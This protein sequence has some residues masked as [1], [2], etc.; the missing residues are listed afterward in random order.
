MDLLLIA[1][2]LILCGGVFSLLLSRSPM[3]A[4]RIGV[5]AVVAG[6]LLGLWPA[7]AGLLGGVPEGFRLPWPV[8]NGEIYV[9][10]DSLSCFF[11]IPIFALSVLAAVYGGTYMLAY[12]GRKSLGAHWFLFN[13]FV[14]GM[15]LVVVAR[16][17]LF[18]LVVW[19]MMSLAA[20]FLVTL[21]HE[22]QDV[23]VAGWMYLIAAHVG[24]AFLFGLF[25][26]LG[27]HA[28]SFDF[29]RFM[30]AAPLAPSTAVVVFILGLVGFGTKAGLVPFHIWLPE[31]HP[32]A[33]SHVSA[34]MS[35]VMIKVGIYGLLRTLMFMGAP[36]PWWGPVLVAIGILGAVLGISMALFQ[37]DIKRV[38]AYSSIE[39]IGLIVLSFGIAFWGLTTGCYWVAY[40][41][42]AG[43]FLHIWNHSMMKGL[44]FL[45]AGSILH[46]TG[47]R[48]IEKLGGLMQRMPRT[49]ALMMLGAVAIAALPPLNGF[50]SEWLIYLAMVNGGLQFQG[51]SG[52][53]LLLLVGILALVGGL[54]L[55]C[56]VRLTGMALLGE[57]RSP[58][59]AGVHESSRWMTVPM[60]ILAGCCV[61]AALFPQVLL[62]AFSQ[63]VQTT[64]A[65]PAP[66]FM[67]ATDTARSPLAILGV[68]NGVI[69][70]SLGVIALLLLIALKRGR[71]AADATWGCGYVAPTAKM[72]YTGKSFSEIIVTRVLPRPFLP[73]TR[74]EAPEGLFPGKGAMTT[75]Y[76]D[77]LRRIFY[78][79]SF[80]WLVGH[81]TRL[82]WLQKGQIQFYMMYFV[83][84]LVAA[85]AWFVLRRW[86]MHE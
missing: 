78:Q 1:V 83:V 19:E 81:F 16:Q 70:L 49:G 25:L 29:D 4:T 56:F 65:V 39:N 75:S 17:A 38:L 52:V 34:L 46:G 5:G 15:V 13:I 36:A 55:I 54:A 18:F 79:P 80:D 60:G 12:R 72:Q 6:C 40:M 21:E 22:K 45:A 67:A 30:A 7:V 58:Q 14:A 10:L 84:A 59:A 20:F 57:P 68:V 33:P 35:G 37:R 8:P 76:P 11:L 82:R 50:V 74:E 51:I 61:M 41:G 53:A 86:V 3:W 62:R 44:M 9:R 26:V 69:W 28:G 42:M 66:V 24:V 31:A 48:D 23:R 73:K 63:A 85:F 71:V 27:R 77:T 2:A 47:T 43:G 32:A 64:F